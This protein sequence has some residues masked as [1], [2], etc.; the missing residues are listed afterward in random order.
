MNNNRSLQRLFRVL[1]STTRG[2]LSSLLISFSIVTDKSFAFNKGRIFGSLS[3][4]FIVLGFTL[5]VFQFVFISPWFA[6][7]IHTQSLI[8]CS[9]IDVSKRDFSD[10]LNPAGPHKFCYF[11][12][13]ITPT[14]SDSGR[15]AP[16][17]LSFSK[18]NRMF[19]RSTLRCDL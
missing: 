9:R 7:F 6:F 11:L 8:A 16:V 18:S 12:S 1:K 3:I 14:K 17:S 10:T 19:L 5:F 2:K 15:I 4:Y 13:V